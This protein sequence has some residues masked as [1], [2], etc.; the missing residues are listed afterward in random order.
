MCIDSQNKQVHCE[1]LKNTD[2]KKTKWK[3]RWKKNENSKEK[4]ERIGENKQC[5]RGKYSRCVDYRK[6]T[7]STLKNND[8]SNSNFYLFVVVIIMAVSTYTQPDI[9]SKSTMHLLFRC[10][11][12]ICERLQLSIYC[13]NKCLLLFH[14]FTVCSVTLCDFLL[15]FICVAF[16][17]IASSCI[18]IRIR[19]LKLCATCAGEDKQDAMP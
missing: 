7:R 18:R 12:C 9:S 4:T 11:P 3:S 13:C 5:V 8:R 16:S 14:R 10:A 17:F 19:Y 2:V 15:V 1:K 6:L